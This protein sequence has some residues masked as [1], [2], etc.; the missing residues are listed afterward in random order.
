MGIFD[1]SIRKV[2]DPYA[3][4]PIMP[5][6]IKHPELEAKLALLGRE[7]PV[8]AS[9]R[10]VTVSILEAA[11]HAARKRRVP[12]YRIITEL[13]AARSPRSTKPSTREE[14]PKQ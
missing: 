12:I 5:V 13:K 10:A 1:Y 2:I 7:N 8:P 6:T 4:T 14:S 3:R 11:V 9:K